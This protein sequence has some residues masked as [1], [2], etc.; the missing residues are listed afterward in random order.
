MNMED[1][2]TSDTP[3][4]ADDGTCR[5]DPHRGRLVAGG[6]MLAVAL[7]ALLGQYFGWSWHSRAMPALLG[8][9]FVVWAALA[10]TAGLLVPGGVLLGVGVGAWLQ[11][12]YGPAAFLW[13]MAGGFLLISVLSL[14]LFGARKNTWWTLWPAGGLVF[15]GAVVAG[16]PEMRA[17]FAWLRDYWPWLLIAAALVL[18]ASGLRKNT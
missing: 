14:A 17:L 8:V 4:P 13:S 15:A 9:A 11:A 2:S 18:I 16:G 1:P 5:A 3:A 12:T 7:L 10:R 6:V